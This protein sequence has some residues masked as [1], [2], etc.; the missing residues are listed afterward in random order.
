MK[1]KKEHYGLA[2]RKI[3]EHGVGEVIIEEMRCRQSNQRADNDRLRDY[4]HKMFRD[5][6]AIETEAPV[7]PEHVGGAARRDHNTING[8]LLDGN[9]AIYGIGAT[10]NYIQR[11]EKKVLQRDTSA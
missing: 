6:I 7:L 4:L 2:P 5:Y 11:Y 1:H 8:L 3:S 9:A 10:K